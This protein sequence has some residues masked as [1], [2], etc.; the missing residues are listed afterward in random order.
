MEQWCSQA[1]AEGTAGSIKY[2]PINFSAEACRQ[3]ADAF[4]HSNW[5]QTTAWRVTCQPIIGDSLTELGKLR[6]QQP[7]PICVF[8]LGSSLG[9]FNSKQSSDYLRQLRKCLH[10]GDYLVFG[11]D[12]L[13][14]HQL[15][16]PAY[17]DSQGLVAKFNLNIIHRLNKDFEISWNPSDFEHYA[18]YNPHIQAMESYLILRKELKFKTINLAA[19]EMIHTEVS[20][21][22]RLEDIPSMAK[23]TGFQWVTNFLDK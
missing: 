15:L 18:T 17:S 14:S 2:I 12:L 16:I 3:I 10:P 9:N 22:Y 19:N 1:E 23:S 21:K 6:E 4:E 8:I 20:T 11:L 7:T 13:K 5:T